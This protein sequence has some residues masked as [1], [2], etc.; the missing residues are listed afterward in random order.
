MSKSLQ[1]CVNC[2]AKLESESEKSNK[3]CIKCQMQKANTGNPAATALLVGSG[4]LVGFIGGWLASW[5]SND[6]NK[7][8]TN[9]NNN[10]NNKSDTNINDNTEDEAGTCPICYDATVNRSFVPCGHTIC[11][12]CYQD[13]TSKKCPMCD[14][15]IKQVHTIYLN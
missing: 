12:D 9:N 2:N 10:N 3:K 13:L 5:W 11:V 8:Q 15:D 1:K 7:N 14:K 4:V 6:N